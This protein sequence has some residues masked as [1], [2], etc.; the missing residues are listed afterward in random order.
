MSITLHYDTTITTILLLVI[1]LLIQHYLN[2]TALIYFNYYISIS[3]TAYYDILITSS[4][5]TVIALFLHHYYLI[6]IISFLR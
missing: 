2:I 3:I 4:L 5:L 6:I 1:A